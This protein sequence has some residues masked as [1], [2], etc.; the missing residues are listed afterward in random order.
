MSKKKSLTIKQEM[1]LLGFASLILGSLIFVSVFFAFFFNSS[2]ANAKTTLHACNR[3]IVTYVEGMF[4]ESANLVDMLSRNQTVIH[5]GYGDRK[6]VTD[7]FDVIHEGNSNITYI[8]SGYASGELYISNYEAPTD[9]SLT[10]RPWYIASKEAQGVARLAYSDAATGVWLFSHSKKLVDE[11]GKMVGAISIDSSNENITQQLSTKYR[12]DSQRS[13]ITDL[14]GKVLIHPSSKEINNSLLVG[15]M[16]ED[17]WKNIVRGKSNYAEYPQNGVKS[18][19]YFERIPNTDFIV[20]TAINSSEVIDPILRSIFY[21]LLLVVAISV[22]LGFI[23]SQ[24]LNYRFVR[25]IMEL[26][27]RIQSVASN[28]SQQHQ[29]IKSSNAEINDIANSIEIIVR[30]ISTREEQRKAA[31]YLSLHDP[32]TGLYNRR[33]FEEELLRLDAPGN[34]PLCIISCDVNGLKLAN[35][36]FGHVAGDRLILQIAESLEK[37]CR[38]N[39]FA[40][41]IGGDEFAVV[42]PNTSAKVAEQ[43]ILRV[44]SGLSQQSFCGIEVSA[45]FG[46][47]VKISPE[48]EIDKLISN[49]DEMMY[50]HKRNESLQMKNNTIHNI[51]DAATA[52]GLV[53]QLNRQEE[54]M[55]D[56]FA[57]KLCPD[58]RQMLKESYRL[59]RI[60]LCSLILPDSAGSNTHLKHNENG[61]RILSILDEYRGI[62]GCILHYTEHWDGSGWPAG[63]SGTDIPLLSRIIAV[64]DAYFSDAASLVP[65][66]GTLYDP[67]LVDILKE[68]I[69]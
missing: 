65:H 21:I 37:A 12:Y 53:R 18:M 33:Y 20:V 57:D 47:A 67:D 27:G 68:S 35:D 1:F 38:V 51:I 6:A 29:S 54:A 36:V 9:Y 43:F 26:G 17:V 7:I 50:S 4:H 23:L 3:Q 2:L 40:A 55:L 28:N 44:Q 22:L 41:R 14:N 59:R 30:D 48:Q 58:M 45:S 19:A 61:Y 15:R 49:A 16:S 32:M 13:F 42:L 24:I 60:G 8:Y 46:F 62:A 69:E 39:D 56:F 64:T 52:E 11:N 31:E 66:K 5:A 63:L 10:K 25:P 34:F